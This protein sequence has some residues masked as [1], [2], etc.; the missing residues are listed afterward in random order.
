MKMITAG[1]DVGAASVK[2]VILKGDSV[3]AYVIIK[4]GLDRRKVSKEAFDAAIQQ[5][6]LTRND[7]EAIKATG[8]GK[9]EA[10]YSDSTVSEVV[11]NARGINYFF[12]EVRT[13]V[14]I[15][16]ESACA[17]R[18][19]S[20]GKVTDFAQ[21]DKCAA[22]V[23]AFV[24]SMARALEITPQEMGLCSL[25]SNRDIPMNATCVVF[26]ESEV[27]SLIHSGIPKADIARAIHSAISN[28]MSSMLM[29]IG[30]EPKVAFIG[31]LAKNIGLVQR[32]QDTIGMEMVIPQEPQIIAALGAAIE[33]RY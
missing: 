9:K 2:A 25:E 15:G 6:G 12:P 14:D 26:A 22:G 7:I 10:A 33:A 21:N 24:D 31:G 19:N 4:S 5:A 29:K 18:C 8:V 23:G 32:L 1:I 17:I 16:A 20:S 3:G 27:V 28:R 30:I 13:V 11:A